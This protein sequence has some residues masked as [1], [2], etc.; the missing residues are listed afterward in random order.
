MNPHTPYILIAYAAS[1]I[2]LF[3]TAILPI[4][5]GRKLRH[6]ISRLIEAEN[7]RPVHQRKINSD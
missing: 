7:H 5:R 3:F 4:L 6:Q 2:I 1:S